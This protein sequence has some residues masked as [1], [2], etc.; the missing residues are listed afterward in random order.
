M[1]EEKYF[2]SMT[3]E[4]LKVINAGMSTKDKNDWRVLI[5]DSDITSV[6]V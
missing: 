1:G 4:E 5:D 3:F 6:T 2:G